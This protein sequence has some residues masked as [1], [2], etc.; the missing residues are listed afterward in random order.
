M[1]DID[2]NDPNVFIFMVFLLVITI[3]LFMNFGK[4]IK[5]MFGI[6]QDEDLVP[7]LICWLFTGNILSLVGTVLILILLIIPTICYFLCKIFS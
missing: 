6:K 3:V 4:F 2:I 1:T 7:G 5:F